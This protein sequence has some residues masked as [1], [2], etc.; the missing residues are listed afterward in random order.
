MTVVRSLAGA[1]F[2]LFATQM[3]EQLN[4]RWASTLL[5]LLAAVM[6]PIPILLIKYG[7]RLRKNS[8][9][10]PSPAQY[11]QSSKEEALEGDHEPQDPISDRESAT[12]RSSMASLTL[13]PVAKLPPV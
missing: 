12:R 4:P 8:K 13:P 2:P 6:A 11:P 9:Y 1:G 5:G 7:P 3:Y 10:G